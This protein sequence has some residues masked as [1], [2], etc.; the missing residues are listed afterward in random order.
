MQRIGIILLWIML[1]GAL[2]ACSG[3]ERSSPF[4]WQG[5]QPPSRPQYFAYHLPD[6][7]KWLKARHVR[8]IKDKYRLPER[9]WVVRGERPYNFSERL[10]EIYLK[11][12]LKP[13]DF[14]GELKATDEVFCQDIDFHILK[15]VDNGF[16][17]RE[18]GQD[19]RN[20]PRSFITYGKIVTTEKGLTNLQY[21][22]VTNKVS[23]EQIKRMY[24]VILSADLDFES[25]V[26]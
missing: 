18:R 6:R 13:V 4:A 9:L 24:D 10:R 23:A 2:G 21:Q 20:Y 8:I 1:G 14:L 26:S 7:A 12:T 16:I 15:K 22:A 11:D 19:C 5:Y 3:D 17:Y 25:T